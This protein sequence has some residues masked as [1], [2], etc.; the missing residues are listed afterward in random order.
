MI[1]EGKNMNKKHIILLSCLLIAALLAASIPHVNAVDTS[2]DCLIGDVDLD[3]VIT[4]SDVTLIQR[5]TAEMT[6]LDE[7]QRKLA[8]VNGDGRITIS[9]ATCIQ[10]YL[11]ELNAPEGIGKPIPYATRKAR[12]QDHD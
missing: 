6:E 12:L 2:D 7:L 11:A 1:Q 5:A 8:D 9:D 3:G 10:R 4:V